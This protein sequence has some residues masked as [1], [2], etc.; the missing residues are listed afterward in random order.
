MSGAVNAYALGRTGVLPVSPFV[1]LRALLQDI[2]PPDTG[3][4]DLSLGELRG[5]FPAFAAQIIKDNTASFSRYPPAGGTDEFRLAAAGW[6]KKRYGL[7]QPRQ[8]L[9]ERCLPLSGSR[10]GLFLAALSL[11]AKGDAIAMPDPCYQAYIAAAC[12]AGCQPV[13]VAAQAKNGFLP[14]Y[15]SLPDAILRRLRAIYVCS[16]ANPQGASAGLDWWQ[17]LIAL[18]RRWQI[19]LLADEAYGDLYP[20]DA[21][22]PAGVLQ[23]AAAMGG[24]D[25]FAGIL[26]F[27]SLSKRS[28]AAGIRGGVCTGGGDLLQGFRAWRLLA[29]PQMPLP[30]QKAAAALFAEDGHIAAGREALEQRWALA[31]KVL[32]QKAGFAR[33][34]VRPAAGFF[35]WLKTGNGEAAAQDLYRSAGVKVLPGGYL[36]S[37]NKEAESYIRIALVQEDRLDAALSAISAIV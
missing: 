10:E 18:A 33:R 11:P 12:A 15:A 21:A 19:P 28:S 32:G 8:N 9:A 35:L 37:A 26:A 3:V 17:N 6:L 30:L 16:P 13:F 24:E 36:A 29:A 2:K 4:I 1:R 20:P 34:F 5:D 22:P 27:Y 7:P 31:E 25:I 14:D 23:A